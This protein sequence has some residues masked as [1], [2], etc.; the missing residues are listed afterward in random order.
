MWLSYV[1][2]QIMALIAKIED[3][4][5]WLSLLASSLQREQS[6]PRD[7]SCIRPKSRNRLRDT[8][9][10]TEV[11]LSVNLIRFP[12][13]VRLLISEYGLQVRERGSPG[14]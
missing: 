8:M 10:G 5:G 14:A 1:P 6:D 11:S 3:G 4:L 13:N 2:D 7:N 12:I 9:E